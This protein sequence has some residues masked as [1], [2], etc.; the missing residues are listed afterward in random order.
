LP[1]PI[2]V[3]QHFLFWGRALAGRKEQSMNKINGSSRT[4][5]QWEEILTPVELTAIHDMYSTNSETMLTSKI[6]LDIIV[7]RN[8]GI[9][10][11]YETIDIISR[12]Y[13]VELN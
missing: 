2:S 4:L 3:S 7:R 1:E 5:K 8:S 12:V 10:S 11:S 6:L 13:G 9:A